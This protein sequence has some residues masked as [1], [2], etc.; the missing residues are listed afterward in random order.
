MINKVKFKT[1]I[2][3]LFGFA[4]TGLISATVDCLVYYLL[5][6]FA[7]IDFRLIQ[8]VSM[9]VG[10]CS[11]F[12][13]NRYFVFKKDKISLSIELV[14]Y[15][16]VCVIAIV[17]S[18]III[19]TYDVWFG[20]YVAKIPATLTTGA[21]NYTLNRLFVYSRFDINKIQNFITKNTKEE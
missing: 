7:E 2:S 20:E 3:K 10:L 13:L 6:N 5:L 8:P 16:M 18:P 12:L 9:S 17:L 11:S 21:I 1:E 19:S 4:F 15:L 14:K